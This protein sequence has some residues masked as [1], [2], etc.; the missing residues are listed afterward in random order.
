MGG[1]TQVQC[2]WKHA[3]ARSA[4]L[5]VC[6]TDGLISDAQPMPDVP[7]AWVL[8]E[9]ASVPASVRARDSVVRAMGA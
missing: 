1:G 4:D 6:I 5:V 7:V 9:G 8:P 2:L 3:Q